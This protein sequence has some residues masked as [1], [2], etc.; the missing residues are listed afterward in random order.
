MTCIVG[1]KSDDGSITIA[2]DSFAGSLYTKS[3]RADKKVFKIWNSQDEFVIGGTYSF[4]MLQ[5]L[6]Y[7]FNPPIIPS[8][9]KNSDLIMQYMVTDFV[10][11]VRSTFKDAGFGAT[12]TNND[13]HSGDQGGEF[14]IAVRG[15][16]FRIYSDYQVEEDI[17]PYNACGSGG[18]L[19]KAAISAI[20]NVI[21]DQVMSPEALLELALDTSAKFCPGIAPPYTIRKIER[22]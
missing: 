11:G 18:E 6:N 19:A 12:E 10:D 21:G 13:N 1:Y 16:L 9:S 14:L 2:G 7:R 20:F 17:L 15:R 5:I 8:S 22:K 4:R 3:I